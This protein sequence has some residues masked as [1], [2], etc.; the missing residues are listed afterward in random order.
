MSL[1]RVHKPANIGFPCNEASEMTLTNST[2]TF[3]RHAQAG[4]QFFHVS[5]SVSLSDP[6]GGCM[7]LKCLV[8]KVDV[9]ALKPS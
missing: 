2:S 3:L 8:K 6:S 1:A 9:E 7:V 5:S 4:C